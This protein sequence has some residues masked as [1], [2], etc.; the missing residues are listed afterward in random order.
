MSGVTYRVKEAVRKT[1]P[2]PPSPQT[3]ARRM[4]DY[5]DLIGPWNM[6]KFEGA[7]GVT[8]STCGEGPLIAARSSDPGS[9][10]A[11]P[12]VGHAVAG[13]ASTALRARAGTDRRAMSVMSPRSLAFA[14]VGK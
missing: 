10:N 6:P 8:I 12:T 1:R 2:W 9:I 13:N 11:A 7:T 5:E 4:N 3:P 14:S